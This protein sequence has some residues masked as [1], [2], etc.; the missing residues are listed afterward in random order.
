MIVILLDKRKDLGEIE[1]R[2]EEVVEEVI[3]IAAD[4]RKVSEVI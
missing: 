3:Q 1:G 4:K 2:T